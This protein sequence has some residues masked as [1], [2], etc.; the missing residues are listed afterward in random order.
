MQDE[1]VAR[2]ANAAS[3]TAR[4]ASLA[5]SIGAPATVSRPSRFSTSRRS[6]GFTGT[7]TM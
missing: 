2:L 1:I 5:K 3:W 6:M 4:A 7:K